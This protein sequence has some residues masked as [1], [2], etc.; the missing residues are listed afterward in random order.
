MG[1]ESLPE[2][3][4]RSDAFGLEYAVPA[5]RD[6]AV[7]GLTAFVALVPLAIAGTFAIRRREAAFLLA[8]ILATAAFYTVYFYTPL[9]PRFL[10]VALPALF[11]LWAAGA[12]MLRDRASRLLHASSVDSPA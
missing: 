10:L 3:T 4:F 2:T 1:Y 12:V 9:H 7:W 6:S 11:V 5:W 8:W